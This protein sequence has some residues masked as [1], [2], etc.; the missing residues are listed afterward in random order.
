MLKNAKCIT[1]TIVALVLALLV[2]S[3][4]FMISAIS[5]TVDASAT[6]AG[7]NVAQDYGDLMQ[8]EWRI[9]GGDSFKSRRSD[10]PA[11]ASPDVLWMKYIPN[12]RY[13]MVVAFNGKVF[14]QNTTH[15][16]ALDPFTGN[17]IWTSRYVGLVQK[18]DGTRMGVGRYC[19]STET[20][21][22]LWTFTDPV[23]GNNYG[24]Y[25][26]EEKMSY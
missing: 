12:K 20:G 26:P 4:P 13:D 14:V 25:I 24:Y 3:S 1:A 9:Q 6:S 18:F 22:L 11:P 8:Y 15:T 23:V 5:T 17:T 19:L 10:G 7:A 21:S 16:F 2:I